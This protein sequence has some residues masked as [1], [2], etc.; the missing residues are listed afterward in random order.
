MTSSGQSQGTVQRTVQTFTG[1]RL[2]LLRRNHV[3]NKEIHG[4]SFFFPQRVN[5]F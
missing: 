1:T 3:E 5:V 4:Q 2:D